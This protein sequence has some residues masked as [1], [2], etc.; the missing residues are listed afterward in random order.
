MTIERH[1][2][3]GRRNPGRDSAIAATAPRSA[4]RS[5]NGAI[6]IDR[7]P[8]YQSRIYLTSVKHSGVW[9]S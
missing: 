9:I 2:H 4:Y 6:V 5:E 1:C 8:F 7:M 3:G